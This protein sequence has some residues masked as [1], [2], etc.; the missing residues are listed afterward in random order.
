MGAPSGRGSGPAP[1]EAGAVR[2]RRSSGWYREACPSPL[3]RNQRVPG[4]RALLRFHGASASGGGGGCL[5]YVMVR[6]RAA[7]GLARRITGLCEFRGYVLQGFSAG[8]A[9]RGLVRF[10]LAVAAPPDRASL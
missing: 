9:E 1:G 5:V 8:P 3:A 10:T 4:R 2:R 7:A 6:A